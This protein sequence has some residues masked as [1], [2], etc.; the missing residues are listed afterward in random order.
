MKPKK[1]KENR[2]ENLGKPIKTSEKLGNRK[3]MENIKKP[4]KTTEN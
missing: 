1:T 2:V 4:W 3:T